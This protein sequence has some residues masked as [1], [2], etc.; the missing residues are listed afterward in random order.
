MKKNIFQNDPPKLKRN[1]FLTALLILIVLANT[2]VS[3]IFLL[4]IVGV[5]DG[6]LRTMS[7]GMVIFSFVVCVGNM[8][9]GFAIWNWH[10]WGVLL[11]GILVIS[12][13]VVTGIVTKDFSNFLSL[14]GLIILVI[15]IF[16]FWKYMKK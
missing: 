11:Y 2:F 13:F 6:A 15:L 16:P 12:G 5:A 8:A 7:M 9:A 3:L 4:N 1:A 10:K 14:V